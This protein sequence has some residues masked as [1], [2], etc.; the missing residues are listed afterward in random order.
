M[1]AVK[2]IM[3]II[4]AAMLTVSLVACGAGNGSP[5]GAEKKEVFPAFQGKDFDG[6]DIDESV[7]AKNEATLLNFWFNGCAACVNEMS[8][9]EKLNAELRERG[10]ELIGVN[11]QVTEQ[12]EVLEEARGILSKQGVSYRNIYING[13]QEAQDYVREIFSFPTTVIVDKQGNIVGK[14]ILG[15]IES[16]ERIDKILNIVDELKAGGD[17]SGTSVV[18]EDPETDKAMELLKEESNIFS[19]HKEVWDK[20]FA[21]VEKDKAVQGEDASYVEFLKSQIE[22]IKDSF[23][24]EERNTLYDD[25]KKIEEIEKQIQELG[26]KD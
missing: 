4:A 2:K 1:N 7:F 5:A 22:G 24:E 9:L 3:L 17:V 10:A 16:K 25:L 11:V 8:A 12:G 21:K 18:S 20:L 15:S 14:P 19:E 13:G 6:N 26:Q 23:S